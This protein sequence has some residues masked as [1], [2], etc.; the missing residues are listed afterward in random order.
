MS[1]DM[2]TFVR[3][4]GAHT[5]AS[6]AV[7][8]MQ[9]QG[10]WPTPPN[11]ELWLHV[12][13]APDSA[14]AQEIRRL[15]EAGEHI[16]DSVAEGL[17]KRFLTHGGEDS[18]GDE[19]FKLMREL[20]SVSE[21][22]AEA[23]KSHKAYGQVLA[24]AT[25]GMTSSD[26]KALE[27]LVSSLSQAT[28]GA[29]DEYSNLEVRLSKANAEASRMHRRIDQMR[30]ETMT[31]ALTGLANRKTLDLALDKMCSDVD[32]ANALTLAFIDID[33][34]KK[35]ND[36]WGH[37]TGDQVLRYVSGVLAR[38]YSAPRLPARYGGEEFVILF[39]GESAGPVEHLMNELREEIAARA[40]HRRSTNEYLGTVT[41]SVG[42]AQR[43]NGE[44]GSELLSRADEALYRAKN[45]GR[46]RVSLAE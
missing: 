20:A 8:L 23:R 43:S 2:L 33:H 6:E 32:G 11:Y 30:M 21:L 37:Q 25:Q 26:I 46:N 1:D 42:I 29:L 28:K 10:V 5:L 3:N 16:S 15:T 44:S 35:F 27:A 12:V 7:G 17:A 24:A 22:A 34:F 40:L 13:G 41:I 38:S 18:V 9:S 14:L 45:D 36:N 4:P 31:D 39:P 19:G